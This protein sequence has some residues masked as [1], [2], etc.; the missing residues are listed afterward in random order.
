MSPAA[1]GL[2]PP[3]LTVKHRSRQNVDRLQSREKE[4]ETGGFPVYRLG[5]CNDDPTLHSLK[6][7]E[8][9]LPPFVAAPF[10]RG[11]LGSLRPPAVLASRLAAEQRL[12]TP[13]PV[14]C[15][16]GPMALN[17]GQGRLAQSVERLVYT[18]DVGGSSPSPP[19]SLSFGQLR[20]AA[21]RACGPCRPGRSRCRIAGSLQRTAPRRCRR[22]LRRRGGSG[23][24]A[25]RPSIRAPR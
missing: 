10:R 11:G 13:H 15:E 22:R 14:A 17:G 9:R 12:R 6:D 1:L 18:E 16:A 7:D 25:A 5:R 19:T 24:I 3:A 23:G 2:W 8:S 20:P 4:A 21:S